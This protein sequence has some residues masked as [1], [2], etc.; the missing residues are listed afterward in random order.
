[1]FLIIADTHTK[2]LDIHVTYLPQYPLQLKNCK[3]IFS[4]MSLLETVVTDNELAFTS[5][6]FAEFMRANNGITHLNLAIPHIIKWNGRA[7]CANI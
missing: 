1:M 2:W 5:R 7:V 4:T 6:E 3:K